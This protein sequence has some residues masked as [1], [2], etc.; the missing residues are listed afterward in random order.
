MEISD[1]KLDELC[2]MWLSEARQLFRLAEQEEEMPKRLL[3]FGA[4]ACY[5]CVGQLRNL[6]KNGVVSQTFPS[7]DG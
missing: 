5:N 1:E 4:M 7:V 6:M 3:E 2:S